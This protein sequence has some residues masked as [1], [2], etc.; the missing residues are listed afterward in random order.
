MNLTTR[1]LEILTLLSEGLEDREIAATLFL[2]PKTVK[3]HM[4]SARRKIGA[5]NRTHAVAIAYREGIVP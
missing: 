4:A 3:F 2:S 5:R 1:E